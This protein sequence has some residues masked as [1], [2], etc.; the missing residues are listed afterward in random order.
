MFCVKLGK[1]VE[2]VRAIGRGG[3]ARGRG[4]AWAGDLGVLGLSWLKILIC[5]EELKV[6]K[7]GGGSKLK[8]NSET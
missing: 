6:R 7:G 1:L 2:K 8:T 5:H 4:R 3:E